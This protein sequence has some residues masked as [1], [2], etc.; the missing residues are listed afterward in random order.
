M[1]TIAAAAP[2]IDRIAREPDW[3][4]QLTRRIGATLRLQPVP[5]LAISGG[6]VSAEHP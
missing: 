2:V 1:R 5:G 3:Q 6:H 4:A